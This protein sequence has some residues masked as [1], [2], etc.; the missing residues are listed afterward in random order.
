[1]NIGESI[2]NHKRKKKNIGKENTAVHSCLFELSFPGGE[3]IE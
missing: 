2:K 3:C 1:M